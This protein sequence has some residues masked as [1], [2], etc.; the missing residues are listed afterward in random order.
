MR[1]QVADTRKKMTFSELET[2]VENQRKE[3]KELENAITQ[4]EFKNIVLQEKYDLLVYK[5]FVRTSEAQDETQPELF[6]EDAAGIETGEEGGVEKETITY[7]RNKHKAGRK[8][9]PENLTRE[10]R[11]NDLPEEEK[12]CSCGGRLERIGEDVNEKLIIEEPRIYVERTVTP[13]YACPCCKG[14]AHDSDGPCVIKQ[15]PAVPAILPGSVASPSMLAHIF[16]AKFAD[17]LPYSR[18]E[19]QFERIGV[20]VSRQDMAN[21][22]GKVGIIL[23][24]LYVLLKD[25]VRAGKVLRMDE[26][27]VQV[28]GEEE[29]KDT[30]KSYMWLAR[31]GPPGKPVVIFKYSSSRKAENIDEFIQGFSGYLQTDGYAGYDSAVR[32]RSDIIHAGCFAHGRRKFFEA[33]KNGMQAKSAVIGINYIKQLYD[34][35]NGLREKLK[36]NELD[37]NN[38]LTQRKERSKV[39]LEKFRGYLDK[40]AGEISA[41]TLLGK[42]VSYTRNQ[43]DKLVAYLECA[44]LTPDNNISE[45]AIRPFV[46]GRKNWLFY[47]SPTGAETACILYSVIETSKLNGLNP[48]KYL[49]TLFERIPYAFSPD[50]WIALLPWNISL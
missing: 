25:A 45:N 18:Q 48:S 13:K 17:H 4:L 14:G 8:P 27:T 31:G 15:A 32:G 36:K 34:I 2:L 9:L 35:D 37:E 12:T 23:L 42:A 6:D 46:V 3:I 49:K 16:T 10:E 43:W 41:E 24:S 28:M 21:W 40:R 38:F 47:K 7:Q 29:R 11:I 33:Q 20:N 44:E 26:T 1:V 5:R 50:D 19:K 39:V 30:R 22:Q